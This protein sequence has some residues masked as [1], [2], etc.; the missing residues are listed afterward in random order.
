ML[1]YQQ[2]ISLVFTTSMWLVHLLTLIFETFLKPWLFLV[3]WSTDI[4]NVSNLGLE[5]SVLGVWPFSEGR[6]TRFTKIGSLCISESGSITNYYDLSF[7]VFISSTCLKSSLSLI[8]INIIWLL[9][10][11]YLLMRIM[12]SFLHYAGYQNFIKTL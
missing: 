5:C 8:H 4:V 6:A 7:R 2:K 9:S 1:F 12:A 10:L 11:V 3:I